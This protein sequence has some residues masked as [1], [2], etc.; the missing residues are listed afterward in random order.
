MNMAN[1]I[2]T[3]SSPLEHRYAVLK[4]ITD[5]V[6]DKAL[7]EYDLIIF[8]SSALWSPSEIGSIT[9]NTESPDA[10]QPGFGV[11]AFF[12]SIDWTTDGQTPHLAF[13]AHTSEFS[14]DTLKVLVDGLLNHCAKSPIILVGSSTAEISSTNQPDPGLLLKAIKACGV[15]PSQA[16]YVS[17]IKN[18]QRDATRIL[19][20]Y[21]HPEDLFGNPARP[22][23]PGATSESGIAALLQ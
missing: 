23:P 18:Y 21:C 22:Y 12:Q 17:D 5:V 2:W 20:D 9:A 3:G 1:Y 19:L 14:P 16:L 13:I 4:A 6:V 15:S 11:N 10:W 7:V 8:E